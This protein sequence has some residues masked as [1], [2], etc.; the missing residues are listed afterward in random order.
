MNVVT[1]NCSNN[2]GSLQFPEKQ[3]PLLINNCLQNLPIPGYGDGINISDWLF[4]EDHFEELDRVSH[5]C[6][7]GEV[8]N[9]GDANEWSNIYIVRLVWRELDKKLVRSGDESCEKLINYAEDSPG[10]DLRYAIDAEKIE[11][12]LKWTSRYSFEQGLSK[13]PSPGILTIR[14][15]SEM[16]LPAAMKTT[17]NINTV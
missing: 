7:S 17:T 16:L 1:T 9:I 3:L 4:V 6:D 11:T 12:A 2:Y 10:N 8:Y 5:E 14:T 15:R 13:K